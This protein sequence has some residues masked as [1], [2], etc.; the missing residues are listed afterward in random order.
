M[1]AIL[2]VTLTCLSMGEIYI[3]IKTCID[4]QCLFIGMWNSL[5]VNGNEIAA[6]AA[7]QVV[8]RRFIVTVRQT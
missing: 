4:R 3:G 7:P 6:A 2:Q 8:R 5:Q 1:R